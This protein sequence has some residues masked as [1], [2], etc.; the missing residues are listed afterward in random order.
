MNPEQLESLIIDQSLGELPHDV[1]A[2]LDGWLALHPEQASIVPAIRNA[3]AATETVV[4]DRPELFRIPIGVVR[5]WDEE[6][7]FPPFASWLSTSPVK[8][9]AIFAALALATSV[10]FFFGRQGQ[11]LIE[12]NVAAQKPEMEKAVPPETSPWAR[13]QI[14]ENGQLAL[15]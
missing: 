4:A 3:L 2:L 11:C 12:R 6:I 13:Y 8:W 7:R 15:V 10:G 5:S 1:S 14:G 9:V